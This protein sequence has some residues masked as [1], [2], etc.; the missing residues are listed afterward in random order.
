[1]TTKPKHPGRTPAQRPAL[2][3]IGSGNRSPLMADATRDALLNAGLIVELSPRH[4]GKPPFQ[5][6]VRQ[7]E[8][9]IPVHMAWCSAVAEEAED[10]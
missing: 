9:P 6:V 5:A 8:M 10:A 2:D 1:M 4:I 3:T 7:F